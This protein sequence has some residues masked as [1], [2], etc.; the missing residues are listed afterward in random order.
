MHRPRGDVC[1][2]CVVCGLLCVVGGRQVILNSEVGIEKFTR[3]GVL[4][5][6]QRKSGGW[7]GESDDHIGPGPAHHCGGG[8]EGRGDQAADEHRGGGWRRE[9]GGLFAN[10]RRLAG[11]DSDR[12]EKSLDQPRLRHRN[13]NPLKI[14]PTWGGFLWHS[15]DER[16][17]DDFCGGCA[18][19]EGERGGGSDWGE[20]RVGEAGSGGGGGGGKSGGKM[21]REDLKT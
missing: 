4:K 5:H 12:P 17:G 8:E 18:A 14:C 21:K 9:P 7:E 15:C 20:R 3:A 13:Q 1:L 10:G 16:R 6:A 11:L 2:L 19:D